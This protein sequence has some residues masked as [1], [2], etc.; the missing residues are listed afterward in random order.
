MN[1][2]FLFTL[3][4]FLAFSGVSALSLQ[5][6][7]VQHPLIS[8][9][10]GTIENCGSPD[11]LFHP[12]SITLTPDPPRRGEDL[13]IDV[14]GTLDETVDGGAYADV[15]VKLGLI[16]LVD[17]RLDLCEEI[18]KIDR[19][20]PIEKGP[21]EINTTVKIPGELPPGKYQVHMDLVNFDEKHIGC[22]QAEFRL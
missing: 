4:A 20:C 11:D 17:T 10:E 6:Q 22:F 2:L 8:I 13:T 19:Q 16:K 7:G 18:K 15:R 5:Y 12:E 3:L 21:V 14:K 9:T 1:R